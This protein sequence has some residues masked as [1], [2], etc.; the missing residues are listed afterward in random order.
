[1]SKR[2]KLFVVSAPSGCGKGTV[3]GEVFKNRDVFYSVSCTTRGPREGEVDGREYHFLTD[4]K[5]EQMIADNKFLEYAGFVGKYY[6]TP[7]EPVEEALSNGRDVVLEIETQG[8]FQVKKSMPEAVMMFILPPSVKELERR[9]KKRGTE[10]DDV[11]KKRVSQARGEIEKSYDY[12][13]VIMNDGLEEAVADFET[14]M[15]SVKNEDTSADSFKAVG[16]KSKK[17][18][19]EVLNY[20][21]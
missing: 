8:A 9:L 21:A 2:G 18:I 7:K 20:D 13:Y 19:E 15:N 3:L 16:E 10:N 4:D 12:D 17:L 6:G 1:M 5:F 11:I 14:V